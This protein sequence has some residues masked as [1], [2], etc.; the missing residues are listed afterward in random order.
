MKQGF[1]A[2]TIFSIAILVSCN[3]ISPDLT[4]VMQE[5][6]VDFTLS[7]IRLGI[8]FPPDST[9]EHRAFSIENMNT[10]GLDWYRINQDWALREPTNDTFSWLPLRERLTAFGAAQKKV[11]L[12]LDMKNLPT[13]WKE[14]AT[15]ALRVS[16][17]S[18]F[19]TQLLTEFSSDIA[20]IQFGNE[21]NWEIDAY[22]PGNSKDQLFIDMTKALSTA[23]A[24][25]SS[26][27]RPLVVLGS[28]SID[29]LRF[30]SLAKNSIQNVHFDNGWLYSTSQ[31][32]DLSTAY[33]SGIDRLKN[34][35][36]KVDFD[37]VD[38]HFYDDYFNWSVYLTDYKALI[39]E[40][41]K[42]PSQFQY[43]AGEFGGP[44]PKLESSNGT[45]AR[46]KLA[47]YVKTLDSMGMST[48]LFFKLVQDADSTIVHPNS[49]L[50]DSNLVA[51]TRYD[52]MK[53]FGTSKQ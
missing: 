4:L 46:N 38:L 34:I 40:C 44:H 27:M 28:L 36:S 22:L 3:S 41:S 7:Q 11:L 42:D 21:W 25:V 18:Q 51:N 48:A 20:M 49:F 30:I 12:T 14:L 8:A 47:L 32:N 31:L 43:I 2:F 53:G 16:E 6:V 10:L 33:T 23:V 26:P 24:S 45:Y 39:G 52:V 17:F 15:D 19:C 50:I 1:A 5:D 13:W 9:P 35:I 37:V 29:G